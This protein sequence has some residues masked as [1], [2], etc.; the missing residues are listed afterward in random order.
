MIRGEGCGRIDNQ[1]AIQTVVRTA[2]KQPIAWDRIDNTDIILA[3]TG[4]KRPHYLLKIERV[5]EVV[6]HDDV[7][8]E[9]AAVG[10]RRKAH[11]DNLCLAGNTLLRS[12]DN[13]HAVLIECIHTFELRIVALHFLKHLH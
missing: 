10:S 2:G 3:Y 11:C 4:G 12:S 1:L 5:D 13:S 8:S 7:A 6:N 9:V